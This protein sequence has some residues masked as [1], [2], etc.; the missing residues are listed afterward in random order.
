MSKVVIEPV[1]T[2]RQRR[3][4]F[5]LPWTIY[6]DDPNWIPPLRMN[7]RELLG[8]KRHPFHDF[9]SMQHFLARLDGKVVGGLLRSTILAM[10]S[11][12]TSNLV[13]SDSLNRSMI[14]VWPMRF[15]TQLVAGCRAAGLTGSAGQSTPP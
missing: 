13:S 7:Q 3:Q 14:S 1:V 10:S 12:T 8:F 15:S 6:Q 4:F 9:A 5:D 2:G 11:D